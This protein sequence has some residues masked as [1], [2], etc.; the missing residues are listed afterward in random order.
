[1]YKPAR[2]QHKRELH[3]KAVRRCLSAAVC[4]AGLSHVL[5]RSGNSRIPEN[6][7]SIPRADN[8]VLRAG[9]VM[10]QLCDLAPPAYVS[11]PA[12]KS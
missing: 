11:F 2:E 10:R 7:R 6:R 8:P 3:G 5:R 1:M 4:S 12:D 9:A